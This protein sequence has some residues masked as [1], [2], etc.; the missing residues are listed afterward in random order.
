VARTEPRTIAR[1]GQQCYVEWSE[2]PHP[3]EQICVAREVHRGRDPGYEPE[4]LATQSGDPEAARRMSRCHCLDADSAHL[5]RVAR[6]KLVGRESGALEQARGSTGRE[7]ARWAGQQAK[8][9]QVEVI[10]V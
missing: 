4:R 10:V 3:L 1:N 9:G 7:R 2:A 6:P 8:R 5:G